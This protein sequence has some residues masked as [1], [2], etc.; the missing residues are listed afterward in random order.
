MNPMVEMADKGVKKID[1]EEISRIAEIILKVAEQ[2]LKD[3]ESA[4]SASPGTS[5]KYELA[6]F[7]D[8]RERYN[9]S[10]LKDFVASKGEVTMEQSD[11]AVNTF[12]LVSALLLAIPFGIQGTLDRGFWDDLYSS[13]ASCN[14][15]QSEDDNNAQ[16]LGYYNENL[17][18]IYGATYSSMIAVSVAV[19]YYIL[20][21][22]CDKFKVWFQ[23][24]KYGVMLILTLTI[25]T[26]V[27]CLTSVGNL[28]SIYTNSS[29]H[30]CDYVR[31]NTIRYAV[32]AMTGTVLLCLA[33]L[34][35]GVFLFL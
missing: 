13:I 31:G 3:K 7:F 2:R 25:I 16:W 30:I 23:R 20:R 1:E 29:T 9:R 5:T 12:V 34:G 22:S 4:E 17:N 33:F 10:V 32:S 35:S 27:F 15:T 26:V 19:M 11:M 24:G 18:I 28:A 8:I 6:G 14:P 21:P